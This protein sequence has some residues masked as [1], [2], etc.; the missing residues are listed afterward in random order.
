VDLLNFHR[1]RVHLLGR[2]LT[3]G[4]IDYRAGEAMIVPLDQPQ[5][6]LIRSMFETKTEFVTTSFYDVSTWTVPLAYG[7]DYAALSGRRLNDNL[8]GAAASFRMP[9]ADEPAVSNYAYAF[10]WSPYYAPR[11]LNRVLSAGLLAR[12]TLDPISVQTSRGA[13]NLGRGSI[14]VAFDRQDQSRETIHALMQTIAR[15]DGL[16]V[17]AVTSGR[18]ATG[19][20]GSDL[21]GQFFKPLKK[22]EVLLVSGRQMDWYNVGEIWHLLDVRM[23]MRVTLKERE[24][25]G[26]VNLNRYTHLVFAGGEY[27]DYLP[28]YAARIR[29]WVDEGGTIIGLRQGAIWVRQNVLDYVDPLLDA[30][31]AVA[32]LPLSESGHDP[33]LDNDVDPERYSYAEKETRDPLELI[34]GAIFS[35]DLDIAH[36][37]GFGYRRRAIALHKNTVLVLTRPANPYATVIAYA[38]PPL[39]SGYAS[40]KNQQ[41]LEGTAGL[42]AE[43]RVEGS[44]ILFA[45]DPNF[46]GTWLFFNVA[47]IT[48][49]LLHGLNGARY[50]IE[51]YVHGRGAQMAVKAVVYTLVLGALAFGIFALLTFDPSN[52][53][54]TR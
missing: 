6:V 49:A 9:V 27:K 45:D 52:F 42:I 53:F 22:P 38:T 30:G 50:S 36:P 34:G 43:R 48:F 40:L 41:A 33:F 47:L 29:Q 15:E 25:L 32:A 24:R 12:V 19:T 35:G 2:D 44:V 20:A 46:R 39:L 5:H 54:A 18:S 13:V 4:G 7:L 37:L 10:E 28:E 26:E 11:A 51:D 23:N 21:G 14:V 31:L 17:H 1:I 3:E 16:F 8:I